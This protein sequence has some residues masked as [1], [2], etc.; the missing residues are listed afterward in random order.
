MAGCRPSTPS[1]GGRP[2]QRPMRH[3]S[4]TPSTPRTSRP[5]R[6]SGSGTGPFPSVGTWP[7]PAQRRSPTPVSGPT[8]RSPARER[9]AAPSPSSGR[10]SCPWGS[11]ERS[12]SGS[13][14]P[15]ARP[16]SSSGAAR[17]RARHGAGPAGSRTAQRSCLLRRQ[18][19][20][21]SSLTASAPTARSLGGGMPP[22]RRTTSSSSRAAPARCRHGATPSSRSARPVRRSDAAAGL[23]RSR[24]VR[25]APTGQ[26]GR[27]AEQ[28]PPAPSTTPAPRARAP[29]LTGSHSATSRASD[30]PTTR[31]SAP[32]G[33]R[34][35]RAD[36]AR[37]W[38]P[39]STVRWP[40]TSSGTDRTRSW[41]GRP[42]PASPRCCRP[43]CSRSRS[44]TRRRASP[45]PWSTTRAA[46]ASARA[47]TSRTSSARS[48]TWTDRSRRARSR[49][50]AP[51]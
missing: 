10:A 36:C 22:G 6:S 27:A 33:P 45:S 41:R 46:Q 32:G 3:A 5:P 12:R 4:W 48:P 49:V 38:E 21:S 50:C 14:A 31:S 18:R 47:P 44:P 43:S 30:H 29:F 37:C 24:C 28:R 51:S 17:P 26:D 35:R 42:G 40:S 9:Q 19:G 16:R 7:S 11:R 1:P 2:W 25:S 34:P 20:Q 13:S 15:R 39:T 23:V 8:T